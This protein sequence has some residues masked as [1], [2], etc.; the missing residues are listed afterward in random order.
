[1]GLLTDDPRAAYA[2]ADVGLE[3]ARRLGLL[4]VAV[5]L[6]SN[7]A[8]AGLD[9]GVWDRILTTIGELD[10]DEL[11]VP[12]RIDLGSVVAT[13]LTWRGDRDAFARFAT[14]EALL[15]T[16]PDPLASSVLLARRA[17]ALLSLGRAREALDDAEA[18]ALALRSTSLSTSLLENTVLTARA[19]LWTGD[20]DRL[21]EALDAI[22]AGGLRGRWLTAVA[23]TLTAGLDALDGRTSLACDRYGDAA[24]S[25]RALDVPLQLALCQLEAAHLLPT[26]STEATAAADEARTILDG[27]G[28]A[29]FIARVDGG[30]VEPVR[31]GARRNAGPGL[32]A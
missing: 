17:L 25:W 12:D 26:A 23:T 16:Q 30:L 19:A 8:G 20:R 15:E 4:D 22:R 27:L 31:S 5:R 29:A 1:V 7:W 6:V 14:L 3:T 21:A 18:T 11:P 28:A 2:M 13:I 9:I 32:S 10:R 24:A